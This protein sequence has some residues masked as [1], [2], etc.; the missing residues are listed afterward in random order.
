[1]RAPPLDVLALFRRMDVCECFSICLLVLSKEERAIHVQI[2]NEQ[3]RRSATSCSIHPA[4]WFLS[5]SA[6]AII[7]LIIVP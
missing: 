2:C 3:N 6:L 4:V 7:D 1:M 5:C